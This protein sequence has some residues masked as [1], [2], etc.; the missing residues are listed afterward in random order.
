MGS[1]SHWKTSSTGDW[2]ADNLRGR[3]FADAAIAAMREA[4]F[5]PL[6]GLIAIDQQGVNDGVVVGFWHRISE[7]LS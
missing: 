5:E 6:L 2:E 7:R 1:K 3:L 4:D